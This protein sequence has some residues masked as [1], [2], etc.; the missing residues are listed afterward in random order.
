MDEEQAG[1][2]HIRAEVGMADVEGDG[3]DGQYDTQFISL[4]ALYQGKRW[5]KMLHFSF[6]LTQKKQ[7]VKTVSAIWPWNGLFGKI[8]K[9]IRLLGEFRQDSFLNPNFTDKAPIYRIKSFD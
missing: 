2:K 6:G 5:N 8:N 4:F 1:G 9:L 7:K 3:G